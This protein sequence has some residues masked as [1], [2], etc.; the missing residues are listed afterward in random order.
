MTTI[1]HFL[2]LERSDCTIVHFPEKSINDNM[3]IDERIVM[4]N[5]CHP[6]EQN[7]YQKV[8]DYYKDNFRNHEGS[9][10]P[11]FHF[12][13]KRPHQDQKCNIKDLYRFKIRNR[14]GG[15][16]KLRCMCEF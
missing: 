6:D 16:Y 3:T 11:I 4:V 7:D 8:V 5:S 14:E 10:K 1:F 9:L 15:L 13:C 2:N 12:A